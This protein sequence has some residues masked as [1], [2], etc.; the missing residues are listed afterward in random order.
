MRMGPTLKTVR[1]S[2]HLGVGLGLAA[3]VAVLALATG[4]MDPLSLLITVGGA[5]GVTSAT[6]SRSRLVSAWRHVAAALEDETSPEDAISPPKR[7]AR[8]HRTGGAPP[9]ERAAATRAD[10]VV[11]RGIGLALEGPDGEELADV[12]FAEARRTAAE[13]E[14]A[15]P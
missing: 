1:R 3:A 14:G 6:Y 5:L 7:L 2:G 12:L 15:R 4:F 10:P 8:L 9:L 11:R 13:S